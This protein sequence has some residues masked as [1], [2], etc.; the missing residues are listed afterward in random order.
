MTT[1]STSAASAET[2]DAAF[3]ALLARTHDLTRDASLALGLNTQAADQAAA[4]GGVVMDGALVTVSPLALDLAEGALEN[5]SLMVSVDTGRRLQDLDAQAAVALFAQ[6]PGLLAVFDAA[7]GCQPDGVIVLHRVL[8]GVGTQAGDL[9]HCMRVS[10]QL[11]SL[12]D[13]EVNNAK[14]Q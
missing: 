3:A 13:V 1:L 2:M 6:A 8:K 14:E 5:S 4:D 11:A 7:I 12:L 10:R 9:A